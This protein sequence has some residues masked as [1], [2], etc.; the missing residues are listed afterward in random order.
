M[1]SLYRRDRKTTLVQISRLVIF[2]ECNM[3]IKISFSKDEL[4]QIMQPIAAQQLGLPKVKLFFD[5]GAAEDVL[6]RGCGS[7]K[8]LK[9][10]SLSYT[11]Q[12]ADQDNRA[13]LEFSGKQIIEALRP[14]IAKKLN[15]EPDAFE[16]EFEEGIVFDDTV[17]PVKRRQARC[18]NIHTFSYLEFKVRLLADIEEEHRAL[19]PE[20]EAEAPAEVNRVKLALQWLLENAPDED[21]RAVEWRLTKRAIRVQCEDLCQAFKTS[22]AVYTQLLRLSRET[23]IWHEFPRLVFHYESENGTKESLRFPLNV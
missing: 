18:E 5:V 16:L 10:C 21:V 23:A 4:T 1:C 14:V 22:N 13:Y 11:A 8:I 7:A 20:E 12:S 15:Q 17:Q 3:D 2:G 6:Y 19:T 9:L